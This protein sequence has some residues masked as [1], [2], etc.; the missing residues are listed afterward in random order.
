MIADHIRPDSSPDPF[1]R[2][3]FTSGFTDTVTAA[4]KRGHNGSGYIIDVNLPGGYAV[5]LDA[6]DRRLIGDSVNAATGDEGVLSVARI[7]GGI[8]KRKE[9]I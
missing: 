2:M 8:I 4:L 9:N 1:E 5:E 3:G 7:I 6:D